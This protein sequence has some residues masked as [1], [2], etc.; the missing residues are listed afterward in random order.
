ANEL[1]RVQTLYNYHAGSVRTGQYHTQAGTIDGFDAGP[2][3]IS[4]YHS[5]DE[6]RD[7]MISLTE[8]TRVIELSNAS[9]GYKVQPGTEDGFAPVTNS[10]VSATLALSQSS[11]SFTATEGDTAYQNQSL[12]FN[13]TG[14]SP[15]SYRIVVNNQPSWLNTSYN[16]ATLTSYPGSPTGIGASLN[17]AGLS[18]GSYSATIQLVGNFSG[19]PISIPVNVTIK[20]SSTRVATNPTITVTRSNISSGDT[21]TFS[22][23][24]PA[25]TVSS[26]LYISCP[27]GMTVKS[28]DDMRNTMSSDL[29]NTYQDT[30]VNTVGNTYIFTNSNSAPSTAVP[31]FYAYTSDNPY[32]GRGV[33][34]SVTV[35]PPQGSPTVTCAS[36]FAMSASG[37]CVAT[38]PA[39]APTPVTAPATPPSISI[40]GS[41]GSQTS[42]SVLN[43]NQGDSFTISGAP[44]GLD[45][46][47]YGSAAGQYTR[48]FNFGSLL[49][50]AC[51][52]N[53]A[54]N[55][56]WVLTC[57]A[58][59]TGN[60]TVNVQ[61]YKDGV[62]YSSNTI[63]VN[64]APAAATCTDSDGGININ[65]AGL[66]DG[67]VNGIGTYFN[68]QS[69]STYGGQ[70]SGTDCTSVAEGYCDNG[71]VSNYLYLCPS[72]YSVNGA[73]APKPTV[74]T[75]PAP[76]PAPAPAPTTA[77]APTPGPSTTFSISSNSITL[78]QSITLTSTTNSPSGT[79]QNAAI[80]Q[81]SDNSSWSSGAP[82]GYWNNTTGENSSHT[83]SCS[84]TPSAAGT[85]YFRS[86]GSDS[87]GLSSFVNQTLT[88]TAPA[89]SSI[90]PS[91]T[92]NKTSMSSG[93]TVTLSFVM[94]SNTVNE[95][96]YLSCPAGVT[97]GSTNICN[98]WTDL[99]AS[100]SFAFQLVNT[101]GSS[102]NVVPN[103]YYYTSDNP[104]YANGVSTQVTVGS[105]PTSMNAASSNLGSAAVG[106]DQLIR[107][108]TALK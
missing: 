43:V 99:N 73:C 16:T 88:V 74:A 78:G 102:Q 33:S 18:A 10:S 61:I 84:F 47:A 17:P 60:T 44:S 42:S 100:K 36:G 38:T 62:T 14:S 40:V 93:D 48:A 66:T 55:Q 52:N 67:R 56:K 7:G 26:K 83:I 54:S 86:R 72:G 28:Y 53:D 13:N 45:G 91:V 23:T 82:C 27:G 30:G 19:S 80:D 107:L 95:R 79:L 5:A 59:Q 108:L 70:C 106:L 24:M 57:S 20:P 31:N 101:S 77:P 90:T 63:T 15:I 81:S 92:P 87:N 75:T 104:N 2:G 69:V 8:L 12:T 1:S 89:A 3:T 71:K 41:S 97:T 6:N 96:L 4:S 68:D 105:A 25:N 39:P 98:Q 34:T 76:A 46:L 58:N 22:W 29:C 11:F 32:Y 35:Q 51:S 103:F 65:V 94:P 49:S 64:V 85:Y 37:A 50:G 21:V 9:G